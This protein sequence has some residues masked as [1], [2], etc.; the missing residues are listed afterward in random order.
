MKSIVLSIALLTSFLSAEELP[1]KKIKTIKTNKHIEPSGLTLFQDNLLLVSDNGRICNISYKSCIKFK[2]KYDLEG[3]TNDKENI[4]IAIEGEDSINQI[5]ENL[6]I[7][8]KFLIPRI[9]DNTLI[10]SEGGDGIEG[11]TY[12]YDKND[13]KYFAISNQSDYLSGP[14]S[15][16]IIIISI[17]KTDFVRIEYAADMPYTD[18]SALYYKDNILYAL[19]DS[20]NKLLLLRENNGYFKIYKEYDIPGKDQE[21]LVVKGKTLFIAQDSGDILKIKLKRKLN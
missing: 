16:R 1:I 3:I 4:Y 19:S 17:D 8:K 18:I 6:N 21:G 5:D 2:E 14:D 11:L 10:L 12:L 15:S 9:T 20:N 7:V 13:K